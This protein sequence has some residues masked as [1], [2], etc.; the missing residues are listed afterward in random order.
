MQIAVCVSQGRTAN[1]HGVLQC[2]C[3][4]L[5]HFF[6]ISVSSQCTS[7][8]LILT[9]LLTV[10]KHRGSRALVSKLP[11]SVIS[12]HEVLPSCRAI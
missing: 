3:G 5:T 12:P 1:V 9:Y 4:L 10:T 7:L 2:V 6:G 11:T 8:T